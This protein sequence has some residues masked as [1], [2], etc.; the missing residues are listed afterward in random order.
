[1]DTDLEAMIESTPTWIKLWE[2]YI[3]KV[4]DSGLE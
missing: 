2:I 1:M 3:I 4:T